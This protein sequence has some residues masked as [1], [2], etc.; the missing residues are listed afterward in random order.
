[1]TKKQ[2]KNY[3]RLLEEEVSRLE[4][5][6]EFG[7]IRDALDQWE[8]D[9]REKL[10]AAAEKNIEETTE[11]GELTYLEDFMGKFPQAM[12]DDKTFQ[13]D[14]CV[15]MLYGNAPTISPNHGHNYK[16]NGMCDLCWNQI[17]EA[18]A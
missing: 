13:S 14:Y 6:I 15:K 11:Q 8:T 5:H 12:V 10:M 18:E 3:I 9:V 4:T 1:M 16:C 17:M 2:L 7:K